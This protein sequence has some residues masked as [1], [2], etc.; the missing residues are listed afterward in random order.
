M[1]LFSLSLCIESL[2]KQIVV[3]SIVMLNTK[4]TKGYAKIHHKRF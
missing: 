2:S 1:T 3:G 4:P